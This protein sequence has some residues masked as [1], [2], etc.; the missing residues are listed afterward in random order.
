M[1]QEKCLEGVNEVYGLHN[2]PDF[3]EGDIRVIPGP[4]FA[5]YSDLEIKVHG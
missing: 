5:A 3:D 1:C 2:I 4:F